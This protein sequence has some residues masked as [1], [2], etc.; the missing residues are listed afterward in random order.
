MFL[1]GSQWFT[2]E[3]ERKSVFEAVVEQSNENNGVLKVEVCNATMVIYRVVFTFRY[4]RVT[5][6]GHSNWTF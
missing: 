4:S 6:L 5:L 1:Q 2:V 3:D